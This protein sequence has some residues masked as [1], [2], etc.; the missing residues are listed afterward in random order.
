[1]S[2]CGSNGE[3]L[4]YG[5][6]RGKE[7]FFAKN[8]LPNISNYTQMGRKKFIDEASILLMG[9]RLSLE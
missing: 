5:K 4:L 6:K 8:E 7:M 3:H 1:M 9:E 2:S